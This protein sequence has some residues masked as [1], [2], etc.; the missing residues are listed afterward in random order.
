[1]SR[2]FLIGLTGG[3]ATGKST[4]A[5]ILTEQ[6]IPV[7]DADRLAREAVAPGSEILAQLHSR[8]G[9]GILSPN[10]SLHR[11]ALA[12]LIFG[13]VSER[14]WVESLIHPYVRQQMKQGIQV[15]QK[16]GIPVGCLM[17][18]L[19]FEAG[20]EDWVD[21][22]WVVACDLHQQRE[23]LRERDHLSAAEIEARLAAQWPL[24]R[25]CQFATTVVDNNRDP[26]QL[27]VLVWTALEGL[28]TCSRQDHC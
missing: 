24:E 6:G 17:I 16:Q 7:L 5:G 26:Q 22:I 13:D 4:V 14:A 9:E 28:P 25:K 2:P 11:Q 3:I 10:G 27:R 18:P 19:L 20:L 15:W 8:Y 21:A 12:T 23:R 1:M